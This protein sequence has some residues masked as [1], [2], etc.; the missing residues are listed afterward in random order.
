[1][2][3]VVKINSTY[4]GKIPFYLLILYLVFEYSRIHTLLGPLES[5]HLPFFTSMGLLLFLITEGVVLRQ[6]QTKWLLGLV[7]LMA[8]HVPIATN[9]YWAFQITRIVFTYFVIH[10]A[11][12]KYVTSYKMYRKMIFIWLICGT[13]LC[14]QGVLHHGVIKGSAF[15]S[16]ENDF[17]LAMN[18]FWEFRILD[19]WRTPRKTWACW[20]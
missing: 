11:I 20:R 1:M 12:T 16:D 2:T 8:I 6:Q 9:N 18:I 13:F 10:L 4:T 15:F 19:F 14:I 5:L 17:S 3:E 7:I